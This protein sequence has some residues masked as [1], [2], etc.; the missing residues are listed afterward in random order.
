MSP[1]RESKKS[2]VVQPLHNILKAFIQDHG[3]GSGIV[4]NVIRR[5]WINIVGQTIAAHTFP[6]TI[7]GKVLT[8][9]VDTPQWIH[10]LSF[11]KEDIAE[12]LRPYD[13]NEVRFRIG[14]LPGQTKEEDR[15]EYKELSED[16]SRYIE[17]TLKNLKDEELKERFRA[18]IVHGLTRKR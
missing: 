11:F 5:Q 17:N 7:K 18:L 8:L 15:P 14:K 12:K 3:L 13:I 2:S 16:D 4:L 1:L 10:H 6:D 9:V